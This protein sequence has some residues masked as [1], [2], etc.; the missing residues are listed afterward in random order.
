MVGGNL[1]WQILEESAPC[2][3][4]R[5]AVHCWCRLIACETRPQGVASI[6]AGPWADER[7]SHQANDGG[8]PLLI[9]PESAAVASMARATGPLRV[10][11][12]V[13]PV[14]TQL[15]PTSREPVWQAQRAP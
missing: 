1:V 15:C 6:V 9:I 12:I 10:S 3:A 5:K 7:P 2:P 14:P 8:M 4:A 13:Q 11:S